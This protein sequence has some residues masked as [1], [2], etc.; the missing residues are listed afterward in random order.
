MR[1]KNQSQQAKLLSYGH[2]PVF[3]ILPNQDFLKLQRG[4]ISVHSQNWQRIPANVSW[5]RAREGLCMAFEFTLDPEFK[6][7]DHILFAYSQPFTR[8]DIERSVDE[9]ERQC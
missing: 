5:K 9:F 4:Q 6:S 3:L 1:I 2:K 7:N 8:T